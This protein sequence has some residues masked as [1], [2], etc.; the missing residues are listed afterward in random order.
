MSDFKIKKNSHIIIKIQDTLDYCTGKQRDNL[1]DV[2]ASVIVG[3]RKDN[4][5]EENEYFICN[6][7]EP[8]AQEVFD[9]IKN[10]E[11]KKV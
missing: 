2:M 3:R 6:T 10:G 1:L 8:Y 7:D 9:V 11:M 4:K 5:I